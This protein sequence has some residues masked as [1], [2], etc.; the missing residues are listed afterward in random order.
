MLFEEAVHGQ[1]GAADTGL[2]GEAV[3]EVGRCRDDVGHVLGH[4]QLTGVVGHTGFLGGDLLR[5]ADSIHHADG[6]HVDAADGGGQIGERHQRIG[7]DDS[8]VGKVGIVVCKAHA[9][10]VVLAALTL[11]VAAAVRGSSGEERDV[12][13]HFPGLHGTGTAAVAADDNGLVHLTGGDHLADAATDTGGLS[14]H[15]DALFHIIRKDI[16]CRAQ[17]GGCNMQIL[18]A[19]LFHQHLCHHAGNVVAVTEL[20][21]EGEGH[22]VVG[23]AL[24]AGFTDGSAEFVLLRLL[25]AD[26]SRTG[27]LDQLAVLVVLTMVDFLAID[28]QVVG[29]ISANCVDHDSFLLS[30]SSPW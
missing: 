28:E 10:A 22:A 11:G 17:G 13:V 7:D 21:V 8:V 6:I 14:L 2:E 29:N 5:V 12:D 4:H 24:L 3:L 19:H 25:V 30:H 16:L 1:R 9:A 26:G 15:D 20:G 27:L 23:T 18:Q